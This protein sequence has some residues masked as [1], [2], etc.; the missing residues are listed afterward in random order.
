MVGALL[1]QGCGNDPQSTKVQVKPEP[2]R[3]APSQPV[4]DD[5]IIGIT[6]D[7][8][9]REPQLVFDAWRALGINAV[10]ANEEVTSTGGFRALAKKN[11]MDLF[12]RFPVFS[13]PPELAED[14]ELVAVTE[15]GDPAK[16]GSAE[17][18]CPSR[19]DFRDRQVERARDIVRRLRPDGIILEHI[20]HVVAWQDVGLD[21][22]PTALPETCFC[23]HCL[24][25]F[26]TFLGVPQS[27]I[28]PQPQRAASWINS[29]AADHWR[30]FRVETITST[31][32]DF[33][34][35][36]RDIDPDI[37]IVVAIVPWR[38]DDFGGAGVGITGQDIP[39]LAKVADCFSPMTSALMLSRPP[40]W[41][42]SVIRDINWVAERPVL[43]II[44]VPPG[45][46]DGASYRGAEFEAALRNALALPSAGVVLDSWHDIDS[47]PEPADIVRRVVLGQ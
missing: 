2:P 46:G 24:Q 34:E 45:D 1:A 40:D 9:D 7:R 21:D 38:R 42:G 31:V 12:V 13:S 27:S 28:P 43:P 47:D 18:A 5:S 39:E 35:A 19:S 32:T 44:L 41:I 3:T 30:R 26:A 23:V 29:N 10:F 16:V 11:E 25:G 8:S 17:F 14:P 37:V 20:H 15:T 36:V 33:A 4:Q 22:D 6:I